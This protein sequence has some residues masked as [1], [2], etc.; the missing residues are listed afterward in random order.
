[1]VSR[2]LCMLSTVSNAANTQ[3]S[4]TNIDLTSLPPT[5]GDFG[6]GGYLIPFLFL[7]RSVLVSRS[8]FHPCTFPSMLLFLSDCLPLNS[9]RRSEDRK[10]IAYVSFPQCPAKKDSHVAKFGEDQIHFVP[11]ISKVGRDHGSHG[12]IASMTAAEPVRA[13]WQY[14]SLTQDGRSLG[15]RAT[16]ASWCPSISCK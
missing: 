12:V 10:S 1:M 14:S 16:C 11:I 6:W 3:V 9:A 4:D 7:L 13:F 8:T 5:R 2:F 15:V